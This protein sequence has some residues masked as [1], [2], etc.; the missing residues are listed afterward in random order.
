M[1]ADDAGQ[2]GMKVQRP[3]SHCGKECQP[4][5]R[6]EDGSYLHDECAAAITT[7]EGWNRPPTVVGSP[8]AKAEEGT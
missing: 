8:G 3:C 7:R 1:L 6:N 4:W 2:L 5:Q